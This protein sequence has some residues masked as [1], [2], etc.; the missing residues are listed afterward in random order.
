VPIE[1]T[2]KAVPFF[3]DFDDAQIK[4]LTAIGQVINVDAQQIVFRDGDD[5]NDLY[6]ILNGSVTIYKRA[7]DGSEVELKAEHSGDFFGELALLDGGKRSAT[8]ATLSACEFFVLPREAFLSLLQASPTLLTKMFAAL[9]ADVRATGERYFREELEKQRLHTE[10][11][12]ERHRALAQMV[13]GVA[14]E[15]NTPLG[16][17][18]TAAG[19][20]RQ[21]LQAEIVSKLVLDTKMKN[22]FDDVIEASVLMEGNVRRAHQLVQSFKNVSVSQ[23]ADTKERLDIAE[24][25]TE[26]LNLFKI[27][28]RKAKL[29]VVFSDQLGEH[30]HIWMGYRGYLS[31]VL[32]NL[33]TNIER[34]AYPR[35]TGGKAEIVLMADDRRTVPCFIVVVRDYGRGIAPEHVGLVF[36]PFFTTG[37][38]E[39]G[40]GL[41]LAI[42]HNIV[43]TALKGAI[44]LESVVG[45]G[46]KFT[47]TVPQVLED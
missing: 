26:T 38:G 3:S 18:N 45:Q 13:A 43:T 33:L 17:I 35:D 16:I 23:I 31:R 5:S 1:Q 36:D 40:T 14:H 28:A 24:V 32:L 6:V 4:T 30:S 44:V 2:L 20:I 29:D 12:L 7:A 47:I 21:R 9:A 25:I 39:G 42:V 15:L 46:T 11:E 10:M 37:R 34:Y 22:V 41:G 19:L 8:V 27:N